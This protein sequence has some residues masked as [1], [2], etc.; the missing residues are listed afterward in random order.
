MAAPTNPWGVFTQTAEWAQNKVEGYQEKSALVDAEKAIPDDQK[1]DP[2]QQMN[3]LTKAAGTLASRGYGK[4]AYELQSQ[5]SNLKTAAQTQTLNQ[6]KIVQGQLESVAEQTAG[7]QSYDG[8]IDIAKGSGLPDDVKLKMVSGIMDMQ[9][10]GLPL[11]KAV[12][13]I[14]SQ[15]MPLSKRMD[16]ERKQQELI[17]KQAVASEKA[18]HDRAREMEKDRDTARQALRDAELAQFHKDTITIQK[19]KKEEGSGDKGLRADWT[20]DRTYAQGNV[21]N[22]KTELS[23]LEAELRSV[24]SSKGD[25]EHKAKQSTR[26][27][28]EIEDTRSELRQALDDYKSLG[29]FDTYRENKLHPNKPKSPIDTNTNTNLPESKVTFASL[30]PTEQSWVT[31]NIKGN[32]GMTRA[33]IIAQ[34][35]KLGKIKTKQILHSKAADDLISESFATPTHSGMNH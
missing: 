8:L 26:L 1:S 5:A 24:E 21:T 17:I 14:Q 4:Q 33:Q 6:M 28:K 18:A 15:S 22:I 12:N 27:S 31:A 19:S 13:N 35:I 23:D 29:N 3:A 16:E 34:G 10:K 20:A 30:A 11:D 25:P 2:V 9:Q 7:A 32:P